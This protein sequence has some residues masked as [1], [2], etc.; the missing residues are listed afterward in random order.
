MPTAVL[1]GVLA[2]EFGADIEHVTTTILISTLASI[3]T[4][5]VILSLVM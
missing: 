4:L 5:S 3:A 2:T 1:A